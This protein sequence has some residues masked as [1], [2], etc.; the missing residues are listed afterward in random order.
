MMKATRLIL[1]PASLVSLETLTPPQR[2]FTSPTLVSPLRQSQFVSAQEF[3]LITDFVR[4]GDVIGVQGYA[5]NATKHAC[6]RVRVA[7]GGWG[8]GA[9]KCMHVAGL[10]G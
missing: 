7:V 1:R 4:R 9:G 8:L 3:K 10:L 5:G 2:R 6:L